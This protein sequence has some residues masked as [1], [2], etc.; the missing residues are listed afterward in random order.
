M[1][2][3]QITGQAPKGKTGDIGP[4]GAN[5]PLIPISSTSVNITNEDF[6]VIPPLSFHYNT[7]QRLVTSFFILTVVENSFVTPSQSLP[8]FQLINYLP[9]FQ[10][11]TIGC[12]WNTVNSNVRHVL[13]YDSSQTPN[14]FLAVDQDYNIFANDRFNCY[15]LYSN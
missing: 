6:A 4:N 11:G 10:A 5:E 2:T 13:Y 12:I 7:V 14:V 9:K 1:I 15:I 3:I 8:L